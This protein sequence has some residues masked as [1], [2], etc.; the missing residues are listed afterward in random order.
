MNEELKPY[1]L[2]ILRQ[3]AASG[4]DLEGERIWML[5]ADDWES[6]RCEE[7]ARRG[8]LIINPRSR[9]T[10]KYRI[11]LSGQAALEGRGSEQ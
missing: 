11:S 6:N 5:P 10:K 8:L 2:T 3:C 4:T 9:K 1:D 7:L